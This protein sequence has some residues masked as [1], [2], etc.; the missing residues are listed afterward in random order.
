MYRFFFYYFSGIQHVDTI[1]IYSII[2]DKDN[3]T[4]R[5]RRR[6]QIKGGKVSADLFYYNEASVLRN[7]G[8]DIQPAAFN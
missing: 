4:S 1:N 6:A 7:T 8:V 3:S 2:T 5:V